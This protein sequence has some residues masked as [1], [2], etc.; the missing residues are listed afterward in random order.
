MSA[1]GQTKK[2]DV[3]DL[4]IPKSLDQCFKILGETLTENELLV[5]KDYPEDSI[6]S[7][8][9]FR[10]GADFFHAW[11]LYDGSRLTKYFNK[12]G[13]T[14]SNEIYE[15]ILISY[16]RYLNQLPIDL[17]GQ[18]KKYQK[19]QEAEYKEYII[20]TEK[21][22]INSIYIPKNIEDC[23]LTLNKILSQSDIDTIK[24]LPNREETIRYHLGL[25]MWLRNN[26]VT[27]G[28]DL[29]CKK[30]FNDRDVNHPDVNVVFDT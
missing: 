25:G 29:D 20:R 28:M 16:H 7:H 3:Y 27:L 17:D 13:L 5:I 14:G 12:K 21:D 26:W 4:P 11:K 10:Y 6:H 1:Y 18:I 15:T 30:Y 23:F 19:K 9:E 2:T 22:S 8:N 24:L